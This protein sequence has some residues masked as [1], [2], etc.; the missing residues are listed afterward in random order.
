M[1]TLRNCFTPNSVRKTLSRLPKSLDET[2]DRILENIPR[3]YRREARCVFHLLVISRR[4]LSLEE[5]AEAIAVDCENETFDLDDRLRDPYDIL[6]IC[7]S[8]V[9]LTVRSWYHTF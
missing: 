9:M 8:L 3:D 2:Y 4:P 6:D 5:V 7:S 1:Q